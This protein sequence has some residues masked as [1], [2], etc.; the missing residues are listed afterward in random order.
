VPESGWQRFG[1]MGGGALHLHGTLCRLLW[2][3]M[4]PARSLADL[5]AGWA[6]GRFA[7]TVTIQC[8]QSAS[9]FARALNAFFWGAAEGFAPWLESRLSSR[10]HPFERAV[11]EAEM[12]TLTDFAAKQKRSEAGRRQLALL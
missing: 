1:P 4:N 12:E 7:G 6:Q 9:E 8:G 5:P 11:I 3:A 10:V 2:L